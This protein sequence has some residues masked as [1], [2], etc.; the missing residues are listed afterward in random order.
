M[1][2]PMAGAEPPAGLEAFLGPF[3]RL[4]RRAENRQALERY[5]TDLL[6]DSGRKSASEL[7]RLRPGYVV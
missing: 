5:P 3:A 1:A 2:M 6:A 4:P 7:G